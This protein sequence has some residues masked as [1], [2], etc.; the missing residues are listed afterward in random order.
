MLR[1]NGD[2]GLQQVTFLLVFAAGKWRSNLSCGF[3][4][5]LM[6]IAIISLIL[7]GGLYGL[8]YSSNLDLSTIIG[9]FVLIIWN[10]TL[11]I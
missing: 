9:C 11:L 7:H 2:L 6:A 5:V 3:L 8:G 1:G 4:Q 10:C